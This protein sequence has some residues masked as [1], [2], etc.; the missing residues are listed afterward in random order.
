MAVKLTLHGHF[1]G[2]NITL[3]GVKFRDGVATLEGDAAQNEG[4]IKY[5]GL[6]YQ[7]FPEGHE[8][9]EETTEPTEPDDDTD[10]GS[11]P[12]FEVGQK[13]QVPGE[14]G[15]LPEDGGWHIVAD[16]NEDGT[17]ILEPTEAPEEPE[18]D[19]KLIAALKKLDPKNDDHWVKDG[20]PAMA[21]VEELYGS[22][23]ITREDVETAIPGYDRKVAAAK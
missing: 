5:L 23:G 22:A 3:A 12:K 4:M 6:C 8:V 16:H 1:K 20:R 21:A 17:P 10:T 14:D 2:R 18:V 11:E 13:I 7:A 19:E 9:P 15:E